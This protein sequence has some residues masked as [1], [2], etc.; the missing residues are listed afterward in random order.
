[1]PIQSY[2]ATVA[3]V[4]SC[5]VGC[6][7]VRNWDICNRKVTNCQPGFTCDLTINRCVP[8]VD[9]GA[10]DGPSPSVDVAIPVDNAGDI[11]VADA[12][13]DVAG[14]EVTA[15]ARLPGSEVAAD[16]VDTRVPD[17][18]CCRR[19]RRRN[20]WMRRGRVA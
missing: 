10:V 15:D 4:A 6:A 12:P 7:D 9:G 14:A 20:R 3:L 1:M 19:S 16:T 18:Q 13:M 8:V 5:L 2:R 17:A 11:A